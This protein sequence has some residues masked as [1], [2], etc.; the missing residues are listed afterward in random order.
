M[1]RLKGESRYL[2]NLHFD[3]TDVQLREVATALDKLK[4]A[5]RT[6][7][8]WMGPY[9]LEQSHLSIHALDLLTVFGHCRRSPENEIELFRLRRSAI[10]QL[11]DRKERTFDD[12]KA[13]NLSLWLESYEKLWL[14]GDADKDISQ[15]PPQPSYIDLIP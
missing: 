1:T 13:H 15:P 2:P 6:R 5:H 14:G 7:M 8:N 11:T 9:S 3:L 4:G 12:A 10:E